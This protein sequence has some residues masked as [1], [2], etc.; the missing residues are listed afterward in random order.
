MRDAI[1]VDG[2][3]IYVFGSL[4]LACRGARLLEIEFVGGPDTVMPCKP[5][6]SKK[7]A[8]K[9]RPARPRA[10]GVA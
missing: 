5:R 1:S 2:I 7:R 3:D 9:P 10:A 6:K 4:G 8:Y